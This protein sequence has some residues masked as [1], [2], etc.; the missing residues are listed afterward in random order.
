MLTRLTAQDLD[1]RSWL[2]Q[3][4]P[5]PQKDSCDPRIRHIERFMRLLK[6]GEGGRVRVADLGVRSKEYAK[7]AF[8]VPAAQLRRIT[9]RFH[10]APQDTIIFER[11]A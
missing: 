6:P 11:V 10:R 1:T 8:V 2:P 7:D 9:I 5:T 3:A 4:S